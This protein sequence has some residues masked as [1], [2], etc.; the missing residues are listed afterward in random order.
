MYWHRWRRVDAT[1]TALARPGGLRRRGEPGSGDRSLHQR[2]GPGH[3]RIFA[4]DAGGDGPAA[5]SSLAAAEDLPPRLSQ[6]PS[7]EPAAG[8]GSATPGN[9]HLTSRRLPSSA[10][11]MALVPRAGLFTRAVG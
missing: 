10:R 3:L 2:T 4:N 6:S 9:W 1:S 11:T 5:L 8:R 7:V